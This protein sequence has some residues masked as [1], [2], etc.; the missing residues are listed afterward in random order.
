MKRIYAR[1]ELCMGCGLCEVHCTVQHSKSKDI[2]KAHRRED[3]RPQSRIRLEE[4]KPLTFPVQCRHCNEPLCAYSCL[5][6]ALQ[7]DRGTGVVK[8]DQD[9][10]IGCGTC[11]MVCPYGAVW[12]KQWNRHK[13]AFKCDLCPGRETPAC[14]E[15]CPNLALVYQEAPP[16]A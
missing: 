7:R 10:C 12:L 9:R 8:L 6:G 5:T 3:P 16:F 11:V 14:V 1:E 4:R 2:T 15:N 13:A